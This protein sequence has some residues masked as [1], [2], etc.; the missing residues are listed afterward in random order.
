MPPI[1]RPSI[2]VEAAYV[3]AAKLRRAGVPT[4]GRDVSSWSHYT[5]G[6]ARLWLLTEA[7]H[8]NRQSF[9]AFM[10]ADL[11]PPSQNPWPQLSAH[12]R[13]LDGAGRIPGRNIK[14]S[15]GSP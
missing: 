1:R 4:S 7:H 3:L 13:G 2:T 8:V 9:A 14:P 12:G 6:A 5:I 11:P 10:G 15:G